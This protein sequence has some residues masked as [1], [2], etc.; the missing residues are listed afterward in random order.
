MEFPKEDNY[1]LKKIHIRAIYILRMYFST[2]AVNVF[3]TMGS[4]MQYLLRKIPELYSDMFSPKNDPKV[5][6]SAIFSPSITIIYD[7]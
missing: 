1:F 6:I 7:S 3:E 5:S 4:G 2:P